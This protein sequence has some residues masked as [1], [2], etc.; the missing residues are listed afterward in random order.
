M[1]LLGEMGH[2]FAQQYGQEMMRFETNIFLAKMAY[3]RKINLGIV[4]TAH[5]VGTFEL[6]GAIAAII[7]ES[8]FDGTR[9]ASELF[10]YVWPGAPKGTGTQLLEAFEEWARHMKCQRVT[11][12]HMVH[13]EGGLS[14]F[15]ERKG[16]QPFETHYMKAL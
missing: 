6:K 3:Y 5:E 8:P 15:Y 14:S 1:K 7:N 10:W 11:M 4:L 16:Y 9:M 2:I 12:A 13:N